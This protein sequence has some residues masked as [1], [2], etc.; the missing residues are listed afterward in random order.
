MKGL[1][2][3][4]PA[5]GGGRCGGIAPTVLR[6]LAESGLELAS[7]KTQ[8]SG[9]ACRMAAEAWSNGVRT[10]VAVGGDGTAYE[11]LNGLYPVMGNERPTIGFLP[12]G[13]GN[14]FIRD[15]DISTAE[16]AIQVL[17]EGRRR[18][19]DIVKL[20]HT[21]GELVFLNLISLGFSARVAA[22]TNRRF[23]PFGDAGYAMAVV[24]SLLNHKHP[25]D[26]YSADGQ[27]VEERPHTLLSFCNSRYTGGKMMM[28]PNADPTDG[29][30]DIIR[31]N[32]ISR[33]RLLRAFPKIYT[34]RHVEFP[35]VETNSARQIRFDFSGPVDVMID[36]EVLHIQ[37]THLQVLPKAIE[38]MI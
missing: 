11:I 27:P 29:K 33:R 23:K 14:S 34:G 6:Q 26:P 7:T 10:F 22:L 17:S 31:I 38:I 9:D 15:F 3:I 36:G 16:E 18:T 5:A 24:A 20:E 4:N 32:A 8:A 1:A 25:V 12:L 21:K 13:T 28:A 35:E 2:I 30:V 37:P 19:C